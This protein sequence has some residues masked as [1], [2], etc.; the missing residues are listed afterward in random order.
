MGWGWR[1]KIEHPHTL[2]I[3]N[4]FLFFA[5]N[6]FV[7]LARRSSGELRCPATALIVELIQNT[8]AYI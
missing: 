2:A 1:S 5:S 8:I 3:L 4:S 7:F 6:A